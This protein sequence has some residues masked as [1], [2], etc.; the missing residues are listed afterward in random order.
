MQA[1]LQL[2]GISHTG[3]RYSMV[4]IINQAGYHHLL[5][6]IASYTCLQVI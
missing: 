6:G 3:G 1:C 5:A 4:T 2:K